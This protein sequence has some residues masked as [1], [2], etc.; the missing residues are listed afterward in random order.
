MCLAEACAGFERRGETPP[1]NLAVCN[2]TLNKLSDWML[3]VEQSPRFLSASQAEELWGLR[4][5]FLKGYGW[6][7]KFHA[8]RNSPR[9]PYRPK[10]H[11][12]QELNFQMRAERLNVRHTHCY[13]EEDCIGSIKGLCRRV[14]RRLLELRVLGRWLIRLD[15]YVRSM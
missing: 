15:R 10:L 11:Y 6:L 12:F 13:V 7:A 4:L 1:D 8:A 2:M 3:K 9:F 5:S 14:H